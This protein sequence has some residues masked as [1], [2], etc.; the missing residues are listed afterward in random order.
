MKVF[1]FPGQGSQFSGMAKKL[2]DNYNDAKDYYEKAK[3]I[4]G[5]EVVE[6]GF[7]A[8]EE[9]LKLT[10]NSQITIF[11]YSYILFISLANSGRIN[12]EKDDIY[13]GHS[14]GEIT[15]LAASQILSF[16][17]AVK[18]VRF[19]GEAMG[20]VKVDEPIMAALLKPDINKISQ[21]FEEEFKDKLFIANLNSP[22]QVVI[23]GLKP[24]FDNFNA[25]YQRTLFLKSIPLKVSA[26]FHSPFMRQAE[27]KVQNEIQKYKMNIEKAG[28]VISNKYAK[29]YENSESAI[30]NTISSSITSQVRWIDSILYVKT[31]GYKNYL[32]IGPKSI[33]IPFVKEIDTEAIAQ[34]FID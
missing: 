5:A 30:K 9:T 16:E 2:Y 19:R 31:K 21:V 34:S 20:E 14:L 26:P 33:L 32:E 17:D 27:L 23:S 4:V 8:D 18:F 12:I 24:D 3:K 1:L 11:L 22:S 7:D 29:P 6:L 15:A 10:Q 25:K 13:M 28:F